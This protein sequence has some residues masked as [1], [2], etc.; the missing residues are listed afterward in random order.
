MT[1]NNVVGSICFAIFLLLFSLMVNDV[2]FGSWGRIV[3]YSMCGF[4]FIGLIV[5]I[6]GQK[7]SAKWIIAGLNLLAF[8]TIAY[9]LLLGFGIGE[10]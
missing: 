7:G 10:A 5:A 8:L 1:K 3:I 6:L 2:T 4:P 9:L